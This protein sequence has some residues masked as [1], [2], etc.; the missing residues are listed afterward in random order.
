ML[1]GMKP[2]RRVGDVCKVATSIK[3]L[4][5][6]DSEIL[7]S[8]IIDGISWPAHTLAT[9]LRKRGLSISDMTIARHRKKACVCFREIG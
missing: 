5:A 1:E 8:A 9:E 7:A 2:A 6:P 3:R 4:D